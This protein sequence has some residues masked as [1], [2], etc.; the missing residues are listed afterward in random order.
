MI[1]AD[2]A[3]AQ[4]A[5]AAGLPIG[6]ACALIAGKVEDGAKVTFKVKDEKLVLV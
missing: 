4:Q 5:A 1:R 2:A 6:T 3:S